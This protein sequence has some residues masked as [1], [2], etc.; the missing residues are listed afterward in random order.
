[1]SRL[2]SDLTRRP[3]ALGGGWLQLLGRPSRTS[4][5]IGCVRSL[6]QREAGCA[7]LWSPSRGRSIRCTWGGRCLTG[8][9]RCAAALRRARCFGAGRHL[10]G[11]CVQRKNTQTGAASARDGENAQVRA[12]SVGPGRR[13]PRILNPSAEHIILSDRT[14]GKI[15]PGKSPGQNGCAARDSNPEPA[16]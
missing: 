5:P 3:A 11:S 14:Y 4:H 16:D 8:L 7:S 10:R 13:D 15:N 1:V 2:A 9:Q 6:R 12:C